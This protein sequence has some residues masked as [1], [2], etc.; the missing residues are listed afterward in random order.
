LTRP[1]H[2]R[3]RA[4]LAALVAVAVAAL[5]LCGPAAAAVPRSFFG[6]MSDGPLFAPTVDLGGELALMRSSGVGSTRIAVD[7]RAIEPAR[8][9]QDFAGLDAFVA[10]A[11]QQRIDVL[12][13]VL[14]APGWAARNPAVPSSPPRDPADYAAFLTALI[15]RYGPAGVFWQAHPELRAQPI[16]RWQIWNEP[17]LGKYWAQKDW[18]PGYVRLLRAAR[19]AVKAGDPK[20]QVVLAGLTN[21]SW[22]DLRRV[23]RAGGGRLFDVA[24]VHPFSKRVANVLKIVGLVRAQMRRYGD[25][26]KPLVLSEVS[27]SSGLGHSIFNYGWE[28]TEAGQA[29][30]LGQALAALAARR[31][32]DHIAAV[33]WYTWLSPAVGGRDSF[34]YAGLRRLGPAGRPVSKPALAAFRLVARR[35]ERGG[36]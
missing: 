31:G 4:L 26:G 8:G 2:A 9:A 3:S 18:A 28:M 15:G 11:A 1:R 7:W 29:A 14:G 13:V 5:T 30:R 16:R 33:Y 24:A 19:R 36:G 27:W 22:L 32:P 17:D 21:R 34:D 10:A 20:A 12:P 25:R 35:L 6:V 23:Y